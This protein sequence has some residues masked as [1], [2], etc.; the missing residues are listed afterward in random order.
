MYTTNVY[1]CILYKFNFNKE[2]VMMLL[3]QEKKVSR[4][5]FSSGRNVNYLLWFR[6]EPDNYKS[7]EHCGNK[8]WQFG[9]D[10]F[11]DMNYH[12]HLFFICVKYSSVNLKNKGSFFC[13]NSQHVFK[14]KL[15]LHDSKSMCLQPFLKKKILSFCVRFQLKNLLREIL[16]DFHEHICHRFNLRI[17]VRVI[18][19]IATI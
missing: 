13:W 4:C 7:I 11:G 5:G 15:I 16:S 10:K 12:G 18:L 1:V 2:Y 14:I 6:V 19:S 8:S 17:N 9:V 3:I